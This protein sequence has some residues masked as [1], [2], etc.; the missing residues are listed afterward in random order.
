MVNFRIAQSWIFGNALLS[1]A[2]FHFFSMNL[3][4]SGILEKRNFVQTNDDRG[5]W[6]RSAFVQVYKCVFELLFKIC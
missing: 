5:V 1:T 6:M 4:K 3:Q 2:V